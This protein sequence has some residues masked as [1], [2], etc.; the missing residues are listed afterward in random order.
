[1]VS[2]QTRSGVRDV[3]ANISWMA[4]DRLLRM[5][6]GVVVG[7]AVARYLG[8]ADFGLLNYALALYAIFNILS[9]LGLDQIIVRDVILLPD[10]EPEL[11][12]TGFALKAAASVLTTLAAVGSTYFLRPGD[13]EVRIIVALLSV[14]AV[15]QACDVIEFFFQAKTKS[16]YAVTAKN[17]A[18][19][20][21]SAARVWAILAKTPLLAFAWIAAAEI[22]VGEL[23]LFT[24]YKLYGNGSRAW[25]VTARTARQF[26]IESWPLMFSGFL[27]MIYMRTD[28]I[29]LGI[30]STPQAV[31]EYSAALKL[32][33]IWYAIP[34][35]VAASVMPK[36][37]SKKNCQPLLYLSRLQR[38]YDAMAGI[39]IS[40]AIVVSFLGRFAVAL[41]YGPHFSEAADILVIHIWTGVFVFAA[42]V[43]SQQLVYEGLPR[44]QLQRTALGA[45][46][47]VALNFLLIPLYG[48]KGSAVST[49]AAQCVAGY[50]ADLLDARSRHI[51]WMKTRAY[52]AYSFWSKPALTV[53]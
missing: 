51:F 5:G 53:P 35:I 8:P 46:L 1:V 9:N 26:L 25:R 10:R 36:L 23:G 6:G 15:T 43:S 3:L 13:R 17:I 18:F 50:L 24:A 31:G 4:S 30:L 47:N 12:G 34:M 48:G 42:V 41:L 22:V 52:I 20:A 11:L 37:L 32:S 2:L 44:L 45:C 14:A 16:K 29:L 28:Q 38:L 27:V 21:A 19:V 39:S 33:E 7:T 40:L 49:L